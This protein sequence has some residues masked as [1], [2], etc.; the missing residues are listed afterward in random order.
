MI[1]SLAAFLTLFGGSPAP[2]GP[3]AADPIA[4]GMERLA[5]AGI[6]SDRTQVMIDPKLGREAFAIEPAGPLVQVSGGDPAGAM[7]GLLELAELVRCGG[8]RAVADARTSARPFLADRGMNIFVTL[9]WSDAR[10][11]TDYDPAALVDPARW[12]FQNESYWTTLLD[13]MAEARLNWLDLHGTWDIA[14]TGAPNLYAYFVHSEVFPEVGVAPDIKAANLARLNWVIERAHARGVRVSLMSYEASLSTPHRREPPYP[15]DEATAFT[16]TRDVVERLIRSAPGLDAIGFRIGESGRGGDFFRCYVEAVEK[17]GRDIPLLTRSWVT[18]KEMVVPLARAASDFTVEIKYDGEQWAAPYPFSGG[19]VAN[20][21]SY[22]FEDYLSDSTTHD[23]RSGT[24][25]PAPKRLWPGHVTADGERWPDEPYKIVWQVRANG[26]HR[27]FPFHEPDWVRRSIE[28]MRLGTA[29]GFTI[30]PINAYFPATPTYYLVD[31]AA[32]PCDW[33]H[34]RD[35][36]YLFEWGRLGYDPTTPDARFEQKLAERFGASAKPLDA[37]WRAA[38]RVVPLALLSHCFGP[39][40]RDHAPELEWGGS[41]RDWIEGEGLDTHAFLPIREEIAL[42]A[43]GGRDG[44]IGAL[45]VAEE[46]EALARTID[47]QLALLTPAKVAAPDGSTLR[48]AELRGALAQLSSL[49]RYHAGRQRSAWWSALANAAPGT[50]GA[51]QHASAAMDQALAAWTELSESESAKRYAPFTDRLRMHTHTFHWRD[52]LPK[53][54]KE[55]EQLRALSEASPLLRGAKPHA[56][57]AGAPPNAELA[58][59]SSADGEA[60]VARVA[61]R[62]LDHAWLLH[63]PLPSSTFFHRVAMSREGAHFVARLP[64]LP[65]GHLLAAEVAIGDTQWRI[66]DALTQTPWLVVPSKTGATPLFFSTGEALA[67]L[68]PASLDP[69]RHGVLVI[70]P[71]AWQLFRDFDALTQRK[72]L[73]VVARGFTLLV[74]QQ[75]YTS[76]RYPLGWLPQPPKVENARLDTFDPGG[77]LRLDVVRAPDIVLQRFVAT[78]GWELHGNGAVAR[79]RVGKGEL[80]MVQ[81]RLIQNLELP[82]AARALLTLLRSGGSVK[83]VILID[84]GTENNRF[85]TSLFPDFLNAHELPFLTLGEVIAQQQ[86]VAATAVMPAAPWDD[87]V[88]GGRGPA[89]QQRFQ[90]A[91]ARTAAA[92]PA[93]ATRAELEA[94]QPGQQQAVRAALGLDPLPERTSL[95]ARVVGVLPRKGYRIEKV[96]YDS[97]PGFPVSAHLYV[98]DGA[99]PFPVILN[100]HG[101]WQHKKLE[102]V[103]QQRLIQQALHGYLALIVDSPGFSFEGDARIER[104]YAGS[105]LDPRNVLGSCGAGAVYV[106]DLMRGLDYLETR[107]EADMTRVG[108]TGASG[109]GHATLWAFAADPRIDAA[110]PVVFATSLEVE[111]HNG[112]PCNHIPGTLRLGD[113]ADVLAARA[114]APVLVLGARDDREFPPAGTELT[115]KKLTERWT[116]FGAADAVGAR[117]FEGPHDYNLA[118]VG[119]ALGFFDRWLK[120]A[121]DGAPLDLVAA[122]TEPSDADELFCLELPLANARTLRDLAL[123]RLAARALV[124][125]KQPRAKDAARF[126]EPQGGIPAGAPIAVRAL[127]ER[128]NPVEFPHDAAGIVA[129]AGQKLFVTFESEPGLTIPALLF[130]PTK[131]LRGAALLLTDLGKARAVERFTI[132]KL[133]L[134]GFACFALD[135]RGFGELGPLDLGLTVYANRSGAFAAAIDL[136]RAAQLLRPLAPMVAVVGDGPVAALAALA[137][138]LAR[139]A[140]VDVVIARDGLREFAD[141][142]D[143]AVPLGALQPQA[144]LLPRLADLRAA[145]GVPSHFTFRGDPGFDLYAALLRLLR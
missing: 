82:G 16:Y 6:A 116:R 126:V 120:G 30:E 38:S 106:W 52:E 65:C 98:P 110:V 59:T 25:A 24:G 92:R 75:D 67:H 93:P 64:R 49:A 134:G 35:E 137:L 8:T 28:P 4:F 89:Q 128:G 94:S 115:G 45:R 71:R 3:P 114:P 73:E 111:P 91:Q 36:L 15:N 74:L 68:D 41:T 54:Q 43:T 10:H 5:V 105:H 80:W 129:L 33:I 69:A 124:A 108:I 12:W 44:R 87:L 143:E 34:Q 51:R 125:A 78:P 66:P 55:A 142:F 79:A 47:A 50:P 61:A 37:A 131:P 2:D 19:R 72:L 26:T 77:A 144:D 85:G 11:D 29:S 141:A 39:D 84:P 21:H 86:G 60:I 107:Q 90:D 109:G 113:R 117:V 139:P 27:I 132:D 138:T 119:H 112:C 96:V 123:E 63:K 53:V 56:E 18:R 31:A 17:S 62:G 136:D 22:S 23:A 48:L 70:A 130:L 1:R 32:R 127:D 97:R 135:A 57:P 83:P 46:Q 118:M 13:Q 99:G 145:V 102:P 133:L 40:H 95:R 88:L 9:P 14:T 100:P 140:A 42:R 7:Y 104:R 121:G 81:A 20:W 58:L 103:V 76:G 101:H 122:P